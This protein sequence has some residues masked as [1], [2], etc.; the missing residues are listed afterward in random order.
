M[1]GS[2]KKSLSKLTKAAKKLGKRAS[3]VQAKLGPQGASTLEA[4]IADVVKAAGGRTVDYAAARV[5]HTDAG[6]KA[7]AAV[8]VGI[9]RARTFVRRHPLGVVAVVALGAACIE[10]ELAVGVLAGVGTAAL[11]VSRDGASTRQLVASGGRRA[12]ASLKDAY[13]KRGGLRSSS[14]LSVSPV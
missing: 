6:K 2:T 1:S 8:D 9:E 7:A 5:A 3:A 13:V 12:L 10:I 11:L 14:V 4:V